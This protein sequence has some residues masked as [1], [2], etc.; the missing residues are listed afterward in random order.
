MICE[1]TENEGVASGTLARWCRDCGAIFRIEGCTWAW[2]SPASAQETRSICRVCSGSCVGCA[3]RASAPA[4]EALAKLTQLCGF[5]RNPGT[6]WLCR[7][8]SGH[9]GDCELIR[10][11]HG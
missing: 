10:G 11:R 4:S 2:R 6:V 8:E 7:R 9:P 5:S 3:L 1:H